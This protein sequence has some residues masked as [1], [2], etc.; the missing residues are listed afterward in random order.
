MEKNQDGNHGEKHPKSEDF[1]DCGIPFIVAADLE[2]NLLDLGNCKHIRKE[3]AES[4]RVGFA[5]GN[6]VLLTH[7][8]TMG[9]VVI[10]PPLDGFIVLSPQV[11]YFR[12][13]DEKLVSK[14]FLY[15]TFTSN[16]F[17]NILSSYSEQSTRKYLSILNQRKIK[18]V[19]PPCNLILEFTE[20][21]QNITQLKHS[22]HSENV[23]LK[24]IRDIL[25]PKLMSGK[26]RV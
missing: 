21:V 26:I 17:Q 3:T 15:Y 24:E 6:D 14:E 9:R 25:L 13:K 10:V 20:R 5:K 19:Y 23:N 1:I 16:Y 18:L 12:I 2:N 8:A 11:T 4:L 22:I 7:K